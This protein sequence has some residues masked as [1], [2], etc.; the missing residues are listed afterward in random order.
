MFGWLRARRRRRWLAEPFPTAWEQILQR[1]VKQAA[2]LPVDLAARWRQRLLVFVKETSWEGCR[3]FEVSEEV[4]VVIAAYAT[5]IV[6]GFDDEWFSRVRHVLVHPTPY[7]G[8]R[9]RIGAEGV[10]YSR[11]DWM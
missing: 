4:R 1:H 10:D 3:D 11:G 8:Q 2:R 6:L 9:A 5:L 7:Q